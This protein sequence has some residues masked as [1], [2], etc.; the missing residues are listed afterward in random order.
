V[1][2]SQV[3]WDLL[4]KKTRETTSQH[5][6]F[7]GRISRA[8]LA[9]SVLD[10][11]RVQFEKT[12]QVGAHAYRSAHSPSFMC[13]ASELL[14]HPGFIENGAPTRWRAHAEFTATDDDHMNSSR[15]C[16]IQS[17][18]LQCA[19]APTP[20]HTPS[21]PLPPRP[22]PTSRLPR[23][24]RRLLLPVATVADAEDGVIRARM[25]IGVDLLLP[26]LLRPH[27]RPLIRRDHLPA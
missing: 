9:A 18:V 2:S 5:S 6:L 11:T 24:W 17:A 25:D 16:Q 20:P 12:A 22:R 10:L 15:P 4:A 3:W 26:P 27:R 8:L 7:S 23:M 19:A 13:L 14:D 21:P 1:W